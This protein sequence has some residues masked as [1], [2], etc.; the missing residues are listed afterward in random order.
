MSIG[1]IVSHAH[2]RVKMRRGGSLGEV[3]ESF[4]GR[5]QP[6]DVFR[7]SGKRLEMLRLAD[8]ELI[9]K[10]A[11]SK[12]ASEVPRWTGGRLPL[13]ETLAKHVVSDFQRLK[14][15]SKRIQNQD[16]LSLALKETATIQSQI[17]HCPNA[18]LTMAEQFKTRDGYHLCV[19]PFAGWLVHQALGPL[20]ATRIAKEIPATITIT[21]NDY[22]IELLSPE[23]EPLT[24]CATQWQSLVR[25]S[26][27]NQDLERALNLSELVRRQF[28][29]TARISGLLFEGYPGR[30]KSL[31]MLQ[32]S[33]GLLYDV[34][35]QYDPDHL[36]LNQAKLD[37]LREEF[38]I[39]RLN[40]TLQALQQ[41]TLQVKD[42][43]Q[44]SPLS[45]PLLIDRLSARLSTE[46]IAERMARLTRNFDATT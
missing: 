13:S 37:V 2:V 24:Y 3:E 14:P 31:R 40:T 33:A 4:A 42:I 35:T 36:L 39:E 19:F 29:A 46:T 28:R 10:P 8:G 43:S 21:V 32:T 15:L 22:G 5:L 38:D 27:V 30:Q 1:T 34:L 6:G 23:P 41:Q 9:V 25:T 26:E 16:W 17:S 44:P 45:L 12:K 18:Q 11:G 7:F 20:I